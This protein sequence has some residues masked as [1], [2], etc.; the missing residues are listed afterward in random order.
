[1]NDLG[2]LFAVV[3]VD[4]SFQ[5]VTHLRTVTTDIKPQK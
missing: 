3:T 1:L 4:G 2:G 5:Q